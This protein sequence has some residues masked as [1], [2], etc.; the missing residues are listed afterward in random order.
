MPDPGYS[1][2][3][4]RVRVTRRNFLK[5]A[6]AGTAVGL[7]ALGLIRANSEAP[8]GTSPVA[9]PTPTA[10]EGPKRIAETIFEKNVAVANNP[11]VL[12]LERGLSVRSSTEALAGYQNKINEKIAPKY[13]KQ[14]TKIV[15]G[16]IVRGGSATPGVAEELWVRFPIEL[17]DGTTSTAFVNLGEQTQGYFEGDPNNTTIANHVRRDIDY[18]IGTEVFEPVNGG[19]PLEFTLVDVVPPTP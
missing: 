4:P 1:E 19:K 17:A 12:H 11:I 5:G 7:A 18:K 8:Q 16:V 6:A 14:P 10:T 3:T 13:Q 9:T 2:R 15:H